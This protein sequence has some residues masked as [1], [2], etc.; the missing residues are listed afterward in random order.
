MAAACAHSSGPLPEEIDSA[1][2]SKDNS[3][4]IEKRS[5]AYKAEDTFRLWGKRFSVKPGSGMRFCSG[6]SGGF[7]H[8]IEIIDG[9]IYVH[10]LP[11]EN[12]NNFIIL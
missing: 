3:Y 2:S 4:T 8:G 5:P 10:F 6:F 7:Y 11:P 1:I 12:S 9:L